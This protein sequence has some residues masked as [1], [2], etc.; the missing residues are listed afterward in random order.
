MRRRFH[1]RHDLGIQLLALYLMLIV[2]FLLMLLVFDR[3]IGQRIREDVQT[4]D[5]SLAQAIAHE[6]DLSIGNALNDGFR[7][8]VLSGGRGSEPKWDGN[9]ISSDLEHQARCKFGLSAG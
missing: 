5:L 8:G 7:F 2:P 6:T 1:F 9:V 4:S 3:L